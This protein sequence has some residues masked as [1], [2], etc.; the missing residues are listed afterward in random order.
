MKK[1][2][3]LLLLFIPIMLLSA[4]MPKIQ[5][6]DTFAQNER[7][8]LGGYPVWITINSRGAEVVGICDVVCGEKIYSPAKEA[9]I[10]TGDV[11]LKINQNEVNNAIDIANE[12]KDG[13]TKIIE[14]MREDNILITNIK[15]QK[16]NSGE[17]KLGLFIKNGIN[18]IGTVT[19]FTTEKIACLGHPVLGQKNEIV[20]CSDGEI[21]SCDITSVVKGVRGRPG[22]LRGSFNQKKHIGE[23]NSNK[24]NGI[25]G[26]LTD[27]TVLPLLEIETSA[28]QMGNASIYT[29]IKGNTPEKYDISIIKFDKDK[30]DKN[31]VIKIT[32]KRLLEI[33]NGIV[34]GMSGSPIVQ[35]GKLVGAVTHVFINDPT[36]GFGISI[37][38][39]L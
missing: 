11:I 15:P 4:F 2:K 1:I 30:E 12:I 37:N 27:L 16:D 38:N 13:Q 5:T 21:F 17:Y 33:S 14:L 9:D 7:V 31:L 6:K 18:G 26:N 36:R 22:E 28:P 23:V 29:T 34:Q 35:N 3:F 25:Y 8:F 20:D 39:M 24:I 19:Y 10:Q 32:D